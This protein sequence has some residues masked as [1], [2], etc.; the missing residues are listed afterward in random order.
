MRF[1]MDALGDSAKTLWLINVAIQAGLLTLLVWRK[2]YRRF[3]FFVAYLTVNLL[4]SAAFAILFTRPGYTSRIAWLFGWGSQGIVVAARACT[5]AEVCHHVLAPYRGIWAMGWRLLVVLGISVL[6]LAVAFGRHDLHAGI[7]TLDLG[8][9]LAIASATAILFAFAKY[10]E[11]P[12]REPMRMLG[13][14]LCLYSACYALNDLLL[15]R[16]LAGYAEIWNLVGMIAFLGSLALWAWAFRV[17]VEAEATKPVLLDAEMYPN[18]IPE[19]NR[20]LFVLNEQ[21]SQLWRVD[22]PRP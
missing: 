22:S 2:D 17:A 20:R 7:V 12:L 8:T 1:D 13:I 5:V 14:G 3:P 19:M 10:Y 15:Q 11:V 21:L 9:E 18:L 16:Y 4:Q 6:V